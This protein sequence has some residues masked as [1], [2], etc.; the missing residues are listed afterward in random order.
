VSGGLGNPIEAIGGFRV[1]E[2]TDRPKEVTVSRKQRVY[3]ALIARNGELPG[4]ADWREVGQGAGYTA[5]RDLAGFYGGRRPSMVCLPD[6]RRQLT[7]DG[8]RR[9]LA[10]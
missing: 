8:W 10:A 7:A 6:G 5:L 1:S 2:G 9:A 4:Q 3:S